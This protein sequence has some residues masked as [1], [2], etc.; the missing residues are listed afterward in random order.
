MTVFIAHADAD[1]A[2]AAELAAFLKPR[3]LLCEL[4]TGARGFRHLQRGDAVVALWSNKSV[5]HVHRMTM[6][7]RILE[8]WAD[9]QL[10]LV[11]L[12]HG[13]LPVGMRDL[14]AIDAS[15]QAA[16]ATMAWMQVERAVREAVKASWTV[17][18]ETGNADE[19]PGGDGGQDAPARRPAPPDEPMAPKGGGLFRGLFK[20]KSAAPMHRSQEREAAAPAPQAPATAPAGPAAEP[21]LFISYAHADDA[22]VTP[23][24]A[25]VESSGRAVWID[26]SIAAGEGWAG[27]IVRG[28]KGARGVIVMCSARAFE[29]DHIKRE[30][31]LADRFKKPMLPMFLE[32]ANMPED[33]EYF[34][35]GVQWLELFKLGEA[36][37]AGAI[38]SALSRI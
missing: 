38:R 4:E 9:Q 28:I 5:F 10:V 26:K 22:A 18:P 37:R 24:V 15:F 27:E 11:K 12:D 6:E 20:K 7:K 17:Q 35:A 8:A 13:I 1:A 25:I 34:F 33:F 21:L 29:S 36:E 30:V 32:A 31:Y 3:G 23:I 14:S 16:R 2:A 19:A